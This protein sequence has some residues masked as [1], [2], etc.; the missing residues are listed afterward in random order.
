MTKRITSL[1]VTT[2][3]AEEWFRLFQEL[4][5][6]AGNLGAVHE[7]INVSATML[8]EDDNEPECD[9]QGLYCDENTLLKVQSALNSVMRVVCKDEQP[10]FIDDIV[11]DAISAMQNAGILF[12]ERK[13]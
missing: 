1:S 9:P 2:N 4:S 8:S 6:L 5:E 11:M 12:R 13:K 3:G 10:E 7:H